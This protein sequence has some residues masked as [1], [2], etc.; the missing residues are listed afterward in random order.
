MLEFLLT[1]GE[2]L[3]TGRWRSRLSKAVGLA[4]DKCYFV[5]ADLL[6]QSAGWLEEDEN[7]LF[8]LL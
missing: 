3:T 8:G 1:E 2:A 5:T 6:K 7:S 4:M